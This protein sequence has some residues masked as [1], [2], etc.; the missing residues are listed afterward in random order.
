MAR[1]GRPPKNPVEGVVNEE[2]V[3]E[4]TEEEEVTPEEDLTPSEETE[5]ETP[6]EDKPA[7]LASRDALI[8]KR[9]REGVVTTSMDRSFEIKSIDPKT[10][11]LTRGTAFLPA[12]NDFLVDPN[13][14]A[15]GNPEI[16]S[17][18]KDI[19]CKAVTSINFV[20]KELE[21][22]TEEETPVE[23]LDIDEQVEIFGAVMELC[24]TEEEREEWSFFPGRIEE[25]TDDQLPDRD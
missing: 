16:Q 12:F 19:V 10:M 2:V 7:P 13:P 22:C 24:S 5:E 4:A 3:P 1:R 9:Y 6:V 14:Q 21:N 17:F 25:T 11:L 18:V 15:I 8:K 23:V 20:D